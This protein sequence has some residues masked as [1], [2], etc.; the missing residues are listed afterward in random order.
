MAASLVG[1]FAGAILG[2]TTGGIVLAAA[3]LAVAG[4]RGNSHLQQARRKQ[5]AKF[6]KT[7][8]TGCKRCAG[9]AG[10]AGAVA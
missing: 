3:T 6:A 2:H 8:R 9:H 7:T 1:C 5:F 10:Q 4:A